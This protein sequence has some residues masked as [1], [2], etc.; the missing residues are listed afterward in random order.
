MSAAAPPPADWRIPRP[1]VRFRPASGGDYNRPRVAITSGPCN[2]RVREPKLIPKLGLEFSDGGGQRFRCA[3]FILILDGIPGSNLTGNRQYAP[4]ARR[5]GM[6]K[7]QTRRRQDTVVSH[8]VLQP[9]RSARSRQGRRQRTLRRTRLA[10]G[11][12]GCHR[13]GAGQ[14]SPPE[15]HTG[16]LRCLV[17]L[18]GGTL[19]SAGQTWIQP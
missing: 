8:G 3:D 16:S 14:A 13:D 7:L 4:A 9:W 12:P 1:Q 17:E 11:A 18:H 19:L 10:A 5:R 15:R 2:L 6:R